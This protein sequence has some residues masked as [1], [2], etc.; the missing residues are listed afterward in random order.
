MYL[1]HYYRG[2]DDEGNSKYSEKLDM[3]IRVANNKYSELGLRFLLLEIENGISQDF[4]LKLQVINM[5]IVLS[6]VKKVG[7]IVLIKLNL[8]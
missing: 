6:I 1:L 2:L 8:F 5:L 3:E 7:K 4:V